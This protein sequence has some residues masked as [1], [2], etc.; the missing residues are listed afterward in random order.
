VLV[1]CGFLG[2]V[3]Q[4]FLVVRFHFSQ[5]VCTVWRDKR[6]PRLCFP[7]LHPSNVSAFATTQ[8]LRVVPLRCMRIVRPKEL[9]SFLDCRKLK[10]SRKH[11]VEVLYWFFHKCQI[12]L[13]SLSSS[14][15]PAIKIINQHTHFCRRLSRRV[16]ARHHPG[17]VAGA[18][19]RFKLR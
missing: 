17:Y 14:F 5:E 6:R 12:S 2:H 4:E 7:I 15:I 16:T 8:A 13:A 9:E 18:K 11:L 1:S 3:Q 10:R 19:L